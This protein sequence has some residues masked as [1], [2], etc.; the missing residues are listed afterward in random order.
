VYNRSRIPGS[1]VRNLLVEAIKREANRL[2]MKYRTCDPFEICRALNIS[3]AF[4]PMG[5][6]EGSCKGFYMTSSRRKIAVINSDLPEH[7]QR[8]ILAHELAHAIL[9][10][11]PTLCTF[12][13]TS[14]LNGSNRME[15]EA[16]IFAAEFMVSD[17]EVFD[18]LQMRLDFFQTASLLEVPPEMLDFKLRLL[19]REGYDVVAPY[20]GRA[21][22][23]KRDINTPLI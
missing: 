18:A 19:Q 2:K 11:T 10:V 13:E 22:F 4:I 16:N 14:V 20:I 8:I 21:D 12:H 6:G 5:K 3:V 17:S 15:Y 9:H 23:L 1:E 7:I